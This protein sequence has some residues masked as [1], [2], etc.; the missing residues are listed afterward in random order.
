MGKM[1][2]WKRTLAALLA[3]AALCGMMAVSAAAATTRGETPAYAKPY[4]GVPAQDFAKQPLS[5]RPAPRS[6]AP[7]VPTAQA[8]DMMTAL[9]PLFV[10]K[11]HE[12]LWGQLPEDAKKQ[13]DADIDALCEKNGWDKDI[14]LD[15]LFYKGGLPAYVQG[16]TAAYAKA[17]AEN[18]NPVTASALL[19]WQFLYMYLLP[20]DIALYIV[21][22]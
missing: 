21:L 6:G 12:R 5:K 16:A 19:A 18:D 11:N 1:R 13:Y 20:V 7:K 8:Y 22:P 14:T 15:A 4:V 17:V 2:R 10:A 9:L 3:A